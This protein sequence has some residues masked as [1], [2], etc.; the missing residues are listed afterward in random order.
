M[1]I[2]LVA[3]FG[4]DESESYEYYNFYLPLKRITE[5]VI[6]YDF[7]NKMKSLGRQGM[8]NDLLETV[9]ES[10]PDIIIFVPHTDQFIPETVD[11]INKYAITLCYFF[12]DIWRQDY[13]NFWAGHFK[14]VTT[15][16]V[17]GLNR[18]RD[19][20][21]T[22]VLYSPFAC[23][24]E[25]F[26]KKDIPKIYDLSF[27]GQFHPNRAWFLRKIKRAG[28]NVVVRGAGWDKGPV[29][30]SEMVDIFNQ[31]RIN[32]NLSNSVSWDVRYLMSLNRPF[33][34]TL[35][36]WRNTAYALF[37]R[38]HKLHEQVKGRH[39]E[40]NSCGGFQLSY[41]VEGLEKHYN[42]GREIAVYDSADMVT[43][44]ID[45]YLKHDDERE[46][47]AQKGYMRTLRDHDMEFR[48]RTMFENIKLNISKT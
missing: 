32:L 42:I 31:S 23:N 12:D 13:S 44:K 34:E 30:Y 21:F 8:N 22:N 10:K 39:F 7:L 36:A 27:I 35:R 16:D 48:F 11:E 33:T 20:G 25:Y 18:F 45:Y 19:A 5:S 29:D 46:E 15:S 24:T 2:L 37:K 40:I 28:F 43:D 14:Y 1:K 6:K 17:N 26:I 47:V 38:D 4:K 3:A 41:Y 9:K